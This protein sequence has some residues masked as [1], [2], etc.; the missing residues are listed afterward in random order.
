MTD[1]NLNKLAQDCLDAIHKEIRGLK[2]LNVI[3][4]GKTGVGKSTLINAMFRENL[5]QTGIGRP[6]T[7]HMRRIVKPDFPLAIYDTR[8]FEL[9]GQI[10]Q[11]I[12]EEIIKTIEDGALSKEKEDDIHCVWYCVAAT[13]GRLEPEEKNFIRTLT[14]GPQSSRVPVIIVL[15]KSYFKNE[16]K[17]LRDSI[18]EENLNVVQVVQVLAQDSPVDEEYTVKAYGLDTLLTVMTESLPDE[19]QRTLQYVQKASL[20][21]KT[22]AA[23]KIVAGFVAAATGAGAAPI[24]FADIT[25]LMPMQVSMIAGITA[26]F[27][28]DISKS[29]IVGFVSSV[30]GSSAMTIGVKAIA[31]NLMK[32]IPGIG[33]LAGSA[34]TGAT[35][36]LL[37]TAIGEAYIQI[38]IAIYKGELSEKDLSTD[39]G[40]RKVNEIVAL[41]VRNPTAIQQIT[42]S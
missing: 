41:A 24:P 7:E 8:G 15:T 2:K 9:N 36:G 33:S 18:L 38:M 1:V 32:L 3:I 12:T 5:A 16:S 34:I 17:K 35:I 4:T 13:S 20:K 19:L 6:V 14:E 29:V 42:H 22:D 25:I 26:V 23:Q 21:A 40:K 10:Q 37:T 27:G 11:Q 39:E 31:A 30:V 28:I